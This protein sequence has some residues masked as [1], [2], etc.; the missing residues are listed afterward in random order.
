MEQAGR[1]FLEIAYNGGPY[2]GWQI[3]PNAVTVQQRLE[4]SLSNL[5]G[6][7]IAVTGCGRTDTG[8]HARQYFLHFDAQKRLP[9]NLVFRLNRYL[10]ED[11]AVKALYPV[12][13]DA[14]ARYDAT[15]RT[16][17]YHI[18]F[19]KDPFLQKL[20]Y[21]CHTQPDFELMQQTAG[22]LSH[23]TDFSPLSKRNP[24]NKHTLCDISYA[25]WTAPDPHQ[26]VF[27]ITGNRFLWNMVR[28]CVGVCLMVGQGKLTIDEF[29][30]T[31][32]QLGKFKSL[33]AVPAHGLYLAKIEYPYIP[34]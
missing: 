17:R 15:A 6:E 5:C 20:S 26:W 27:E 3:Q 11:I 30:S 29:K 31:M 7:T 33:A 14:H 24:D 19:N 13:A 4:E 12:T 22:L 1:Y 28:M 9:K 10:E 23:Y 25:G 8:V 16:Y 34:S 18:H 2:H 21:F 32:D